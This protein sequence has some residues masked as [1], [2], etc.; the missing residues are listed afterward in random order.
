MSDVIHRAGRGGTSG[1]ARLVFVHPSELATV[2]WLPDPRPPARLLVEPR[3]TIPPAQPPLPLES[4][5][6]PQYTVESG[7]P[8]ATEQ[9]VIGMVQVV[10]EALQGRRPVMQLARWVAP[11]VLA[12][13]GHLHRACPHTVVKFRSARLQQATAGAV[14]AAVHLL[15]AGNSRAAALRLVQYEGR[16]LCTRFET[17]LWAPTVTRAG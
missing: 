17:A 3:E 8:A 5:D 7:M 9:A 4:D 13:I 10:I 12:T 14:E 15:V 6:D 16:W 1:F 11:D 2:T